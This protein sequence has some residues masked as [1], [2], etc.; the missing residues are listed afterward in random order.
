MNSDLVLTNS[1]YLTITI[2]YYLK[3]REIDEE[4]NYKNIY[5]AFFF[6]KY[7]KLF[8]NFEFEIDDIN[9]EQS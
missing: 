8:F 3:R 6:D 2:I 1:P 7:L 9:N 4:E 5:P